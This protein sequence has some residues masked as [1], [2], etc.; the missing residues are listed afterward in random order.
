M[1][2]KKFYFWLWLINR[3]S[4]PDPRVYT[5]A[6]SGSWVP[7][8]DDK[9]SDDLLRIDFPHT[10]MLVF[11]ECLNLLDTVADKG[12]ARLFPRGAKFKNKLSDPSK[13]IVLQDSQSGVRS[14]YFK[15]IHL[16]QCLRTFYTS[17]VQ[18]WCNCCIHHPLCVRMKLTVNTNL[19][20][21]S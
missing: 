13:D 15:E 3:P 14:Q 4:D 7:N 9:H 21:K 1:L 19:Y 5:A 11:S 8:P 10:L 12:A 16:E 17:V 6:R 18:E 2:I 20:I